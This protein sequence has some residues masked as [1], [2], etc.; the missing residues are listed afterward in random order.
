VEPVR[1]L[2]QDPR[3]RPRQTTKTK[4]GGGHGWLMIGKIT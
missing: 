3:G 2:R 1:L 4:A